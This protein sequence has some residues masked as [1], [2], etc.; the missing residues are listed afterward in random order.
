[1]KAE[2]F[3]TNKLW[4][5]IWQKR[6]DSEPRGKSSFFFCIIHS[7]VQP[8]PSTVYLYVPVGA[9]LGHKECNVG[10]SLGDP[11]RIVV[12]VQR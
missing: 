12:H 11:C 5:C 9:S 2:R 10:H 6:G 3:S 8:I 1:M 4:Q 7:F